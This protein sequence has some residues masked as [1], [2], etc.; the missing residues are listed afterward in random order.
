M[1]ARSRR[2][3]CLPRCCSSGPPAS[4]SSASATGS[5]RGCCANPAPAHRAAPAT[6]VTWPISLLHPDI[7]WF[8]PIARP[9]GDEAKQVEE[10]EELLGEAIAARRA[11]PLYGR[12]DGLHAALP[13]AG[14][15][16]CTGSAMMRPV[17]GR[18]KVFLV[19]D[20]RPTG[21]AGLQPGGGQRDAEG[22]R[23]AAAG[24]A[25]HP[26]DARSPR[27]CCPPSARASCR[28]ACGASRTADVARFLREVPQPPVADGG[29]GAPRRDGV[30]VDRRGAGAR[31]RGA[32]D[33]AAAAQRL[34]DVAARRAGG[35][36]PL[37]DGREVVRRPGRF[38]RDA[39]RRGRVAP[40]RPRAAAARDAAAAARTR[41]CPRSGSSRRSARSRR[42]RG[43]RGAT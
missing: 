16:C 18:A 9:K 40:Q 3:S 27:P 4:G 42:R 38:Q 35:P 23:G 21:A 25:L 13:P 31:R 29:G 22:A 15:R 24:H 8:F 19:G 11:N 34:L 37:R 7:H 43:G 6:P 14:A 33:V 20:R 1:P 17:M 2:G 5:R 28:S 12:P 32:E 36:L 30:R 41:R 10:A 26:H 39:R